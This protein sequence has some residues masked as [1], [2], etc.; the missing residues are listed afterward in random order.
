MCLAG[1]L[2]RIGIAMTGLV[3]L[4]YMRVTVVNGIQLKWLNVGMAGNQKPYASYKLACFGVK[5]ASAYFSFE[6]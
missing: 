3:I 2:F 5:G 6:I 4:F 1:E